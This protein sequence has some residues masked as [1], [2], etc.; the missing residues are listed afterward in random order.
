MTPAHEPLGGLHS[1]CIF[2]SLPLTAH[3][4]PHLY[5]SL[6]LFFLSLVPTSPVLVTMSSH[7]CLCNLPPLSSLIRFLSCCPS[8]PVSGSALLLSS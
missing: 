5:I 6:F 2:S 8:S 4:C 1:L 3:L 7:L